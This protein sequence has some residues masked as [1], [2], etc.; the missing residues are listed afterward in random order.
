MRAKGEISAGGQF[1]VYKDSMLA[2]ERPH[3]D[4]VVTATDIERIIAE[5]SKSQSENTVR[6]IFE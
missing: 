3:G 4:E 2:R 1:V 5:V 6:I